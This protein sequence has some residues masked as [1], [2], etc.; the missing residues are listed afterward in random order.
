M[1]L[2]LDDSPVVGHSEA[3]SM[4]RETTFAED[5]RDRTVLEAT[6]R[7]LAERV[8]RKLRQSGRLARCVTLKLR[9][10]DFATITRNRTLP[11]ATD[12]DEVIFEAGLKLLHTALVKENRAVRLISIGVTGFTEAGQQLSLL[13][14]STIRMAK[15]DKAVD[16]IREKYGFGAIQTGRTVKL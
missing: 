13:D 16:R 7:Y 6:L 4:S 1:A 5:L 9:Y 10:T 8:G 3:K 11:Q 14:N 12:A 2:G 15:L